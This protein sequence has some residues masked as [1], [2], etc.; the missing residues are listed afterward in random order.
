MKSDYKYIICFDVETMGLNHKKHDITEIAMAAINCETLEI[1]GKYESIIKRYSDA[2]YDVQAMET[3]GI[4]EEDLETKGK[5]VDDVIE[6]M[7]DFL[8]D[9]VLESKK[10]ILG[11]HNI[12]NFDIDFLNDLFER[13]KRKIT[14]D[15]NMGVTFDTIK[16]SSWAFTDSENYQLGTC[17]KNADIIL[18]DSHRAMNDVLANAKLIIRLLKNLRGDGSLKKKIDHRANFVLF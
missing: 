6:E 10:P 15:I 17:C 13:R 9:Y 1:E 8:G 11:G 16:M 5:D 2:E 18:K 3:T 4:T 12:D 14:K 7:L